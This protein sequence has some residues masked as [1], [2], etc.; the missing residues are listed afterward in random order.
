VIV[1]SSSFTVAGGRLPSCDLAMEKSD[2]F[3]VGELP[4]RNL[5][6]AEAGDAS[7]NVSRLDR[8]R[9]CQIRRFGIVDHAERG[10][11]RRN[12][13]AVTLLHCVAKFSSERRPQSVR[14]RLADHRLLAHGAVEALSAPRRVELS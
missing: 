13:G 10:T 7:G 6:G 1:A 14:V 4:P 5:T 12:R 11:K 9:I 3:T 8:R 2:E